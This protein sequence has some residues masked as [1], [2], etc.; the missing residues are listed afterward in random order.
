MT[1]YKI[2]LVTLISLLVIS[3]TACNQTKSEKEEENLP[4]DIVELRY[5]QIEQA[6][7]ETGFVE[8]RTMNGL[9]K[10]NGTV[11]V[12]P[13]NMATVCMP[14]GG[15]VKSTNLMPGKKVVKG[16]VLAIL[17]NQDFID[18]QQNYLEAK[19]KLEFAETDYN[20]HKELYKD[21]VYSQKNLQL[22]ATEFKNLKAQVKAL[23]QKLGLIGINYTKLSE[24]NISRSVS[25]LSPISGYVKTVNVSIGKSVSSSDVL[26]EIVNIDKLFL[27]L[28]LN[29]SDAH[30][31]KKNQRIFFFVNNEKEQHEAVIYQV[32]KSI[33]SD[34]TYKVYA[35]VSSLCESLLPGMY[36]NANI[37]TSTAQSMVLP[38]DAI[39]NFDDKDYIFLFEKNKEENGKA[40]TEYRIMEVKK[41]VSNDT[42]QE[43]IFPDNFDIKTTKVVV[44]GAYNLLS[45]MKNAGEMSC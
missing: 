19:N 10:V 4:D 7:I 21:D 44:K 9:I 2:Y 27:E 8:M 30:K 22:V 32:A 38:L 5:D 25:L 23:E 43:V 26:Y 28:S 41:G 16:Q 34:N 35:S 40:F 36:V 37:E 33:N 15:F 12:A 31:V 11:S 39:V 13:Q 29:E 6:Q 24:D 45:A 18:A 3:F 1:K 14:M 42:M 20:R 17:E